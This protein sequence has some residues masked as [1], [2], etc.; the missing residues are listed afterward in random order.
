MEASS[1]Y[2]PCFN[3]QKY[4]QEF[5]FL[6]NPSKNP[7]IK[8]HTHHRT[9]QCHQQM[10][11]DWPCLGPMQISGPVV[12]GQFH[13][14]TQTGRGEG[15]G[16]GFE[17]GTSSQCPLPILSLFLS[18]PR[19]VTRSFSALFRNLFSFQSENEFLSY[20]S[21][22]QCAPYPLSPFSFSQSFQTECKYLCPQP[23][24]P[25]PATLPTTSLC[26]F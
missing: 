4:L 16:E 23:I 9:S 5:I 12:G 24:A 21:T 6:N 20:V 22:K 19:N 26:C 13:R 18:I 2:L 8:L 10:E 25:C 15:K 1:I 7:S 17:E 14:T 11:N 3:S